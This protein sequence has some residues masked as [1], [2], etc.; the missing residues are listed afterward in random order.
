MQFPFV[1][2]GLP[3]EQY[4]VKAAFLQLLIGITY[5]CIIELFEFRIRKPG[6]GYTVLIKSVA[7]WNSIP[8][9]AVEQPVLVVGSAGFLHC[10]NAALPKH[11]AAAGPPTI[12]VFF[13]K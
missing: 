8:E 5:T 2:L 13:K 11:R 1:Y 9:A 10:L 4:L 12:P 6:Y 7:R 3:L